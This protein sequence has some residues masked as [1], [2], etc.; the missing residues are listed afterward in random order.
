MR[1]LKI[2]TLGLT[3]TLLLP[4]VAMSQEVK[5]NSKARK[6]GSELTYQRPIEIL[7][8]SNEAKALPPEFAADLLLRL[9]K[10]P[11]VKDPAWKREMLEDAFRLSSKGEQNVKRDYAG[12]IRDSQEGYRSLSLSLKLDVLSLQ[13]RAITAM[14]AIDKKRAREMFSEVPDLKVPTLTCGDALVPDVTDFYAVMQRI[15]QETFTP[16]EVRDGVQLS[17]LQRYV[18]GMTSPT[19]VGPITKAISQ[20]DL[21][22]LHMNILLHSFSEALKK[23]SGDFR[24]FSL[25]MARDSLSRGFNELAEVSARKGVPTEELLQSLRAYL[26]KSFAATQCA[27][28]TVKLKNQMPGFIKLANQD[29]LKAIPISL[30]DIQPLTVEDGMKIHLFWESAKSQDMLS[31]LKELRFDSDEKPRSDIEKA[32]PA[33]HQQLTTY[34]NDLDD[35]S[36][37]DERSDLDYFHQKAIAYRVLSDIVPTGMVR[38]TVWRSNVAFLSN[39]YMQQARVEWFLHA[40]HLLDQAGTLK[41]RDRFE[42]I[43]ILELSPNNIIRAYAH[44]YEVVPN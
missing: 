34:L 12:S 15:A 44:F 30:E 19:Q 26:L 39:G 3:L 33:W 16:D 10:S 37:G 5:E 1:L 32:T 4:W 22:P 24:T 28:N 7:N 42:L 31:R 36:A 11:K 13:S 43:K 2:T 9:T 23:I 35:W 29:I 41:G 38:D 20:L 25:S 17:F 21:S 18:S 14:L 40:G 6:A 8:V 27:D